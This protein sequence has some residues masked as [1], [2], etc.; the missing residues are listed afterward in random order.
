MEDE[1]ILNILTSIAVIKIKCKVSD[2]HKCGG[3]YKTSNHLHNT[4]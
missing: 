1:N 4:I 2:L 3:G